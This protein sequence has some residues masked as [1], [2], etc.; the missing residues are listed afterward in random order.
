MVVGSSFIQALPELLTRQQD[1]NSSSSG[2]D[3]LLATQKTMN[4]FNLVP[5]ALAA[6]HTLTIHFSF[7]VVFKKTDFTPCLSI[8]VSDTMLFEI[9]V[10]PIVIILEGDYLYLTETH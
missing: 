1:L 8:V 10:L 9:D 4:G 3:S 6:K 7:P 5:S 2:L